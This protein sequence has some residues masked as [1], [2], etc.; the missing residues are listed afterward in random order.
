MTATIPSR[1]S[2]EWTPQ[3]SFIEQSFHVPTYFR[4]ATPR[5]NSDQWRGIGAT[6]QQIISQAGSGVATGA[7][8]LAATGVIAGA[9][10]A[11]TAGI[12]TAGVLLATVLMKAFAGCG[13]K[14]VLTS[15]AANEI[16][17]ALVANMRAYFESGRTKS[18]QK[19]ALANFDNAWAQL[20][21]YCGQA[22]FS[23]AGTNCIAD[24]REGACKWKS[25]PGHF[26][27]CTWIGP[28]AAGSGDSCWNY[29]VGMRDPI[30][31]DPCVVDDPT[32]TTHE[33]V[34]QFWDDIGMSA[35]KTSL[36]PL[37]IVA[38]LIALAVIL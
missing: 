20:V 24:R 27:G 29:F 22:S 25:S 18:A 15:Q 19:A 8:L 14:C 34:S 32:D 26:D 2:A 11:L 33:V 13:Q 30:A 31:N 16:G 28:G 3:I 38:G 23:D 10:G 7:S 21:Q 17:D 9:T 35:S 12:A 36:A 37:L 5:R 4:R 1:N 6:G